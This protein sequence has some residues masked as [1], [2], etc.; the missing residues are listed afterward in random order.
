M[1]ALR[2]VA[3][4]ISLII[5][6]ALRSDKV[7]VALSCLLRRSW[8]GHPADL[9]RLSLVFALNRKTINHK[10]QQCIALERKLHLHAI[11]LIY[12]PS[13]D[14]DQCSRLVNRKPKISYNNI[15]EGSP[16]SPAAKRAAASCQRRHSHLPCLSA[17]KPAHENVSPPHCVPSPILDLL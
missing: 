9:R 3:G 2:Q 6:E 1:N 10:L 8:H 5:I 13:S 7:P 17:A 15:A 16:L 11:S 14:I 12:I 4:V